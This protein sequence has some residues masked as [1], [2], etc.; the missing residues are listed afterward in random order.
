MHRSA[1][2]LTRVLACAAVPVILTVAGCS[3]DS[4]KESAAKGDKKSGSSASSKPGEKSKKPELEKAAFAALPDP[5][6]ALQTAT[7]DTLVPEAKDKNGTATKSNDLASRAS[8]SWNGLDEDG[9]KGSQYR[10]LSLSFFRTDSHASLGNANKRAEEQYGKQVEAAK[11]TE[12][13]QNVKAEPA[14]GLGDQGTSVV[15]SVKK[16]VDF[17][18]TTIV[19][20]TQ[21]V[22]VTLDYNG[23]AYEGAGAPDQAKLLQDALTAAKEAVASVATAN[24][25]AEQ[26][27]SPQPQ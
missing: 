4:G 25:P 21:N 12:G 22:V 2:R 8:C 17:F 10:W 14:E 6:K 20:R 15:Y 9:L 13:A 27:Q 26:P 3:S 7:I 19:A 24:K 23:A 18:N 1:S 11:A 5:C 16:D